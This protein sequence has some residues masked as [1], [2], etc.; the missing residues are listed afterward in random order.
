[1]PR[2]AHDLQHAQG[3]CSRRPLVSMRACKSRPSSPTTL[4]VFEHAL[5]MRRHAERLGIAHEGY[6][7][8]IAHEGY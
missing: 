7:G 3:P 6:E 1:V 2:P 8:Y 5:C 4:T